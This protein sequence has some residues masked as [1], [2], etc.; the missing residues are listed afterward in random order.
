M[1]PGEGW[2]RV[3]LSELGLT[4]D[5]PQRTPGGHAVEFDDVRVHACSAD[6]DEVYFELS[7]H[8]DLTAQAQYEREREFVSS[9]LGADVTPLTPTT[10]ASLPAQE[11][12]AVWDGN[13]RR[14]VLVERGRWLYRVVYDPRSPLNVAVLESIRID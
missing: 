2:H 9:R 7:R 5:Y 13:E 12:G 11:F 8:L 6:G 3:R 4:F 1:E 14:F 10:L